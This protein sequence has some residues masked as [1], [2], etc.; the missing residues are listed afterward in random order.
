[1]KKKLL[2]ISI[3]CLFIFLIKGIIYRQ[4]VD[5]QE[6]NQRNLIPIDNKIIKNDLDIFL[7]KNPNA[8]VEEIVEF[9]LNFSTKNIKYTFGKCS[10]NPNNLIE[11]KLTNCIGYSALFNAVSRYLLDKKGFNSV[12]S[13]HKIGH[14][15]F[16][17][18]NLH[19]LFKNPA[20][21]D[22]DYNVITDKLSNKN[23]Q[24]TQL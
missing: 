2:K 24:L 14:L 12:K 19:S 17:G 4:L 3:L 21:K 5:Y 6:V 10:V 18:F 20:F 16:I 15:F 22:H 11:N 7:N 9:S 13:E 8:T 23:T 1:M